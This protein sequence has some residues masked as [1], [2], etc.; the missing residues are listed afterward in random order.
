MTHTHYGITGAPGEGPRLDKNTSI[1]PSIEV[2]SLVR[3]QVVISQEAPFEELMANYHHL[4]MM[5]ENLKAFL[6]GKY[7]LEKFTTAVHEARVARGYPPTA[8]G[9]KTLSRTAM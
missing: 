3:N 8:N 9:V 7:G 4:V 5:S 1:G 2:A 6:I